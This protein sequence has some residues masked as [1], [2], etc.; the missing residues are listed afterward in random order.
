MK[1]IEEFKKDPKSKKDFLAAIEPMLPVK[2]MLAKPLNSI[3]AVFDKCPKGAAEIKYDGERIQIHKQ[4]DSF[5]YFSRN[6]KVIADWKVE[7]LQKDIP[8]ATEA[9]SIILDGEILL[10]DTKTH[11][12]LPFTSLNKH[13]KS[14]FK[15]ASVCT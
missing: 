5:K 1:R 14:Q 9:E 8:L 7:A 2:P 12:P 11:N 4:G 3:S 10:I 13:K 6:L 15:D